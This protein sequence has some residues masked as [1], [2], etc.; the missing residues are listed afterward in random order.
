MPVVRCNTLQNL[1]CM[2]LTL[3]KCALQI[4]I[5]YNDGFQAIDCQ[6]AKEVE[7]C[8]GS[9]ITLPE[10]QQASESVSVAKS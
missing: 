1:P 6:Q 8:R 9:M 3:T 4:R 5:C 10:W 2:V 7:D